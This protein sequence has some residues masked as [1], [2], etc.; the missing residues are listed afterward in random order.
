[1]ENGGRDAIKSVEIVE[2]LPLGFD[3]DSKKK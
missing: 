2:Q 3:S 1:M